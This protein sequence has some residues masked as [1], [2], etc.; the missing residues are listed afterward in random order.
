MGPPVTA[1]VPG[2]TPIDEP[3]NTLVAARGIDWLSG[4]SAGPQGAGAASAQIGLTS[5]HPMVADAGQ[6]MLA[7]SAVIGKGPVG[8]PRYARKIVVMAAFGRGSEP[9][10]DGSP[11]GSMRPDAWAVAEECDHVGD[12]MRNGLGE[13]GFRIL[14]QQQRVV[15]YDPRA[16]GTLPRLASGPSA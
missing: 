10:H 12:L 13:E 14:A 2:L 8:A 15:A 7:T 16:T 4:T 5:E 6:L 3:G 1:L 11:L 9:L